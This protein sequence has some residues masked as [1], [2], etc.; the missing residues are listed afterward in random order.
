MAAHEQR[1]CHKKERHGELSHDC[2]RLAQHRAPVALRAGAKLL[3]PQAQAAVAGALVGVEEGRGLRQVWWKNGRER[4][5]RRA[6]AVGVA[7][8]QAAEAPG[9]GLR[10]ERRLEGGLW[11]GG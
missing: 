6:R 5:S 3:Q 10:S 9:G 7:L 11:G 8:D 1:C 4:L 2:P